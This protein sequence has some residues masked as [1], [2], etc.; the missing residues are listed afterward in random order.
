MSSTGRLP[1]GTEAARVRLADEFLA[2]DGMSKLSGA[3]LASTSRTGWSELDAA[4]PFGPDAFGPDAFGP[5]AFGPDAFG[6]DA[7]GPDAF[8]PDAFG[9]D[10]TGAAASPGLNASS[11]TASTWPLAGSSTF[12]CGRPSPEVRPACAPPAGLTAS[13]RPAGAVSREAI[14]PRRRQPGGRNGPNRR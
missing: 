10:A 7:F 11:A 9:P 1:M 5:D 14:P 4:L 8:G 6:P 3:P 12:A 2:P 13:R